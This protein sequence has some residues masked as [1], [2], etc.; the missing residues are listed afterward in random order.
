MSSIGSK[1]RQ[2]V[3]PA[4][5]YIENK[6]RKMVVLTASSIGKKGRQVVSLAVPSIGNKCRRAVVFK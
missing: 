6:R 3:A 2:V 5:P 1:V 4:V